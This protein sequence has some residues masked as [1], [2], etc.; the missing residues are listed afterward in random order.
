MNPSGGWLT[1]AALLGLLLGLWLMAIGRVIRRRR[2]LGAGRTVSLDK[3]VLRSP[4]L[5]LTS[6]P[7]RLIK[8]DGSII[9]EK[10]NSWS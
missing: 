6:R 2:G 4:R 1:L 10:W 5:G 9:I 3:I 8:A 7:Y